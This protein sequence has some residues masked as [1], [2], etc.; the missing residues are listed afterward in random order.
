M[1]IAEVKQFG[2]V[3]NSARESAKAEILLEID[4]QLAVLADIGFHYVVVEGTATRQLRQLRRAFGRK[5]KHCSLC[6]GTK[7]N[8]STCPQKGDEPKAV[9]A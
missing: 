9:A 2:A 6:G 1:T 5:P 7:H 3:F 4:K 8:V